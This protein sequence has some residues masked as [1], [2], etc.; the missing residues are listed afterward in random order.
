[1]ITMILPEQL[2]LGQ[3]AR[4]HIAQRFNISERTLQRRLMKE[5]TSFSVILDQV[6]KTKAHEFLCDTDCSQIEVA[7][8]CGFADLS[9][10]HHA[11]QRWY[12]DTPGEYRRRYGS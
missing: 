3:F 10:F 8:M 11:F 1:M 5:G 2:R 12:G 9:G 7:F 6:R 4:P